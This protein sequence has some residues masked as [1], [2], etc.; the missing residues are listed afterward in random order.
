MCM[1]SWILFCQGASHLQATPDSTDAPGYVWRISH[2]SAVPAL[3]RARPCPVG[4]ERTEWAE[5][6]HMVKSQ[7]NSCNSDRIFWFLH[8]TPI[9]IAQLFGEC[10]IGTFC[11]VCCAMGGAHGEKGEHGTPLD[12]D[13][14]DD[15][16]SQSSDDDVNVKSD[17]DYIHFVNA[18]TK[19]PKLKEVFWGL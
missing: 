16:E 4:G 17:T 5:E 18:Y 2:T 3:V 19:H 14:S 13:F 1:F 10:S 11:R 7:G 15:S 9:F 6:L 8:K 12:S